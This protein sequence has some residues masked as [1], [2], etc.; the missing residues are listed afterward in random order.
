VPESSA[1]PLGIAAVLVIVAGFGLFLLSRWAKPLGTDLRFWM[2]SYALYLLAVFFPQSSTFRLLV[3]LAP[4][5]GALAIP[6]HRVYRVALVV[7]GILGQIGWLYIAWWV[8][9]QDFTPP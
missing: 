8:D 9:G 1:W 6:E 2:L 7:A 4:G 3:P 5:L